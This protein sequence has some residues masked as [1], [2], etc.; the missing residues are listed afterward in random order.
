MFKVALWI[1]GALFVA[2]SSLA[3]LNIAQLYS[4]LKYGIEQF[5]KITFRSDP[6]QLVDAIDDSALTVAQSGD[7]AEIETDSYVDNN[8]N[9]NNTVEIDKTWD[10]E[11]HIENSHFFMN[12]G[13]DEII[14]DLFRSKGVTA[15]R[16]LDEL[17][18]RAGDLEVPNEALVTL[19]QVVMSS[20]D[21]LA[22]KAQFVLNDLTKY[23]LKIEKEKYQ[24]PAMLVVS[25]SPYDPPDKT[26][27]YSPQDSNVENYELL[28]EEVRPML[29]SH[30]EIIRSLAVDKLN[31]MRSPEALSLLITVS[32]QE[33]NAKTRYKAIRG[34][35]MHAAD[36][37]G[38]SGEII[39]VLRKAVY[40]EDQSVASLARSALEDFTVNLGLAN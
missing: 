36:D 38:N 8:K 9:A 20:D 16:Y 24:I 25:D 12:R 6:K 18:Q 37:I 30:E 34:I 40:D 28:V 26:A 21:A 33:D 17:W 1:T 32:Y 5:E 39:N 27:Q 3:L 29:A 31:L 7:L 35:W 15:F 13:L 10:S 11:L 23:K 4:N 14:D 22:K 2:I 19:E